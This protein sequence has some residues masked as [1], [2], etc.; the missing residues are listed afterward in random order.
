MLFLLSAGGDRSFLV[1]QG[2][3]SGCWEPYMFGTP[4]IDDIGLRLRCCCTTLRDVA[5]DFDVAI[6]SAIA[7]EVE[8]V[9]LI[10]SVSFDIGYTPNA[11]FHIFL[12]TCIMSLPYP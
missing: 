10:S 3:E 12:H 1:A 5:A 2:L 6:A 9:S 7:F 11:Y 4:W 8:A